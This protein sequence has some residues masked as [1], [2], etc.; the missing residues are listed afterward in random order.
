[1]QTI[2][3]STGPVGT[4]LAAELSKTTSS[5]RLVSRHPKKVSTT[6]ECVVA[7]LTD[8][9]A[10]RK[11][12]E[13]SEICYLTA[14]LTYKTSVWREQWPLIMKN[15]ITACEAS[16][17]KLIFFDNVYALSKAHMHDITES[18]PIQPCSEKG[19]VRAQL[20]YDVMEA[21]EKGRIHA[22]I[23]RSP[24]F[25]GPF[26]KNSYLI[27][28][29]YDNMA[30]GKKAQWFCNAGAPH[31]FGFITDLAK[32]TALLGNTP[33][34]YNQTWN[35]PVDDYA[36]TGKEWVTLFAEEMHKK[37]EVQ[38][39]PGFGMKLLGLFIPILKEM[40]EMR[41]QFAYP[42]H[43]NASKFTTAFHYTPTSNKEAV[44]QTIQHM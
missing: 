39:L 26:R 2:L 34:A 15:V 33:S 9:A 16:G 35:L 18:T 31:S 30:K 21:V 10:T 32:G 11:A 19:K 1:M 20:N 29:V 44:R 24:D 8:P 14:G 38:V 36:P 41:Y 43:F 37:N 25:F 13:G 4:A 5:L 17:S 42:F 28:A 22:I 6:D 23:A 12:V 27:T 7:D 40:V 3:G